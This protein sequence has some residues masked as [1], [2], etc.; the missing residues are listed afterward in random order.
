MKAIIVNRFGDAGLYFGI[1]LTFYQFGSLD[2]LNISNL[3]INIYG[4]S[5]FF[6][7]YNK[8]SCLIVLC[9]LR[10]AIGKSAQLGLHT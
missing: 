4:D 3:S 6:F 10:G 2:F 5:F 7:D 8:I 9:I 1:I